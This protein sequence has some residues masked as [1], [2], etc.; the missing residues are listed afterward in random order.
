MEINDFIHQITVWNMSYLM[1]FLMFEK[2]REN[3]CFF[4]EQLGMWF[5]FSDTGSLCTF[6]GHCVIP[7]VSNVKHLF[8]KI[9]N[10]KHDYSCWNY[11]DIVEIRKGIYCAAQDSKF[12]YSKNILILL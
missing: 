11:V 6:Q 2:G 12:K 1:C 3:I 4:L 10:C 7:F 8:F 5:W 9:K